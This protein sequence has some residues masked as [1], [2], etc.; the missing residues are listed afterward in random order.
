MKKVEQNSK[1]YQE[2]IFQS[3]EQFAKYCTAYD[4]TVFIESAKGIDYECLDEYPELLSDWQH[5]TVDIL[6]SLGIEDLKYFCSCIS[7]YQL[8]TPQVVKN[9][10]IKNIK[11][12]IKN[13]N[14]APKTFTYFWK[15]DKNSIDNLL[16]KIN[17]CLLVKQYIFY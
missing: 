13:K 11:N 15:K 2:P 14:K 9:H 4:P 7:P 8:S 1:Q 6:S 12:Q 17:Y 3:L 16:K 10:F 5:Q